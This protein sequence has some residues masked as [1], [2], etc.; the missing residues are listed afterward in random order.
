[1]KTIYAFTLA[2]ITAAALGSCGSND[3]SDKPATDSTAVVK[4][5]VQADVK[6]ELREGDI[7]SV[8]NDSTSSYGLI[9]ILKIE[10]DTYHIRTYGVS[11]EKRPQE[12]DI[13]DL[14]ATN[15]G[16]GHLPLGKDQFLAWKPEPVANL[17]VSGEELEGYNAWKSKQ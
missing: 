9:K 3:G 16:I 15:T 8:V 7:C 13:K 14:K 10:N 2:I 6:P 1:M 4:D 12:D 5:S 17:P 11:Y